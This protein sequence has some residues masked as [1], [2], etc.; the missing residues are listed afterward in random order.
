MSTKNNLQD[1]L[2][3]A[4]ENHEAPLKEAQWERLEGVLL[5]NKP[6]RI[7]FPF[8]FT[9][10][11][12]CITAGLTY[13]LTL[14]YGMKS[15]NL[16]SESKNP[17]TFAPSLSNQNTNTSN[18]S[19][20][21]TTLLSN[22]SVINNSTVAFA[23][24]GLFTKVINSN[25]DKITKTINSATLDSDKNETELEKDIPNTSEVTETPILLSEQSIE[26]IEE[27]IQEKEIDLVFDANDSANDKNDDNPLLMP[28]KPFSKFVLSLSAGYSNMNHKITE[29]ENNQNLHKDSR[30]LFDQSN[31]NP[32]IFFINFGIDYNLF[33]G[34]NIGLN[35]GIQ[36]LQINNPVNIKYKLN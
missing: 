8:M 16:I 12:V 19:I 36:Y 25:I 27:T 30:M 3:N 20:N 29:I 24:S 21:E 7:L 11:L 26:P 17:S 4:F 15:Q 6:K 28:Y 5:S 23:N 9:F 1:A 32:N 2:K 35:S 13:F 18:S 34:L 22:K 31:Q 14:N 33:P 10:F